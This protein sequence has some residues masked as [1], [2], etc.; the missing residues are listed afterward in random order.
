MDMDFAQ[1]KSKILLSALKVVN[2]P[3]VMKVIS[4]PRV[5]DALTKGLALK[6]KIDATI[7]IWKDEE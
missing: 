2:D 7:K 1:L 6:D 4:H 3:R 5:M